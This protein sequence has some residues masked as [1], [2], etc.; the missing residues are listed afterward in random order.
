MPFVFVFC[1]VT[2]VIYAI[3]LYVQSHKKEYIPSERTCAGASTFE[4]TTDEFKTMAGSTRGTL[5]N[6]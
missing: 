1:F 2:L 3:V 6:A 5:K 4:R